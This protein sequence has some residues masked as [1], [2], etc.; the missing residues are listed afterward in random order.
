MLDIQQNLSNNERRNAEVKI[1]LAQL[2]E[3]KA[4]AEESL[5]AAKQEQK[6]LR[7]KQRQNQ[8]YF[9]SQQRLQLV[10]AIYGSEAPENLQSPS[11]EGNV[12]DGARGTTS[13][14]NIK[15]GLPSSKGK[16]KNLQSV[17]QF[18]AAGNMN[19]TY[20]MGFLATEVNMQDESARMLAN[21]SQ[22]DLKSRSSRCRASP[23]HLTA[24]VASTTSSQ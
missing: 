5:S 13:A 6:E 23:D 12:D 22:V 2:E 17:P 19:T 15:P 1:R 18:V 21:H 14:G 7:R 3:D 24:Q 20:S 16:G 8:Q 4:R 10:R 9:Q 11:S